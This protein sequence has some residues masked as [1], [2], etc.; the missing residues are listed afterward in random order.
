MS[1]TWKRS[2]ILIEPPRS[3]PW[4]LSAIYSRLLAISDDGEIVHGESGRPSGEIEDRL[5]G[6]VFGDRAA[7]VL[8]IGSISARLLIVEAKQTTSAGWGYPCFSRPGYH[9]WSA[10]RELGYDEF[11]ARLLY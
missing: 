6:V 7:G 5:S 8:G 9:L 4:W 2:V 10:L 11:H 1:K 3:S